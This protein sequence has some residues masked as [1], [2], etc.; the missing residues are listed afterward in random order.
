MT[1][2]GSGSSPSLGVVIPTL[3]E[4][5]YLP[6]LLA[7]LDALA[8]ELDLGAAE[9][10]VVVSDGGSTDAT[11]ELARAAGATVVVTRRGR[12]HQMNAGARVL[13]TPWLLFLYADSRLPSPARACLVERLADDAKKGPAYFRFSLDGDGWFWRA[14]EV[15]QSLRERVTGLAY[16]DQGLLVNRSDLD[17]VGGYSAIPLLEDVAMMRALRAHGNVERLSAAL[18]T[19]PRRFQEEGRWRAWFRN[20]AVMALALI[21]VPPERLASL[22]PARGA[23]DSDGRITLAFAKAPTPGKVKTRLAARIGPTAAADLYAT[24][25]SET[26]QRLRSS[27]YDLYACYDPPSS[28]AEVQA[29]LGEGVTLTPQADGDLGHR[30]WCALR[31]GLEMAS[32]V[33]VV[34]TDVPELDAAIVEEA[35]EGLSRADVVI[36]PADDGGYYLLALKR[37]VRELFED[38][39][40]STSKVLARTLDVAHELDL[41]VRTLKTLRDIDTIDD[42]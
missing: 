38:I 9:L 24:M 27:A 15:G 4:A 1:D 31:D 12:A 22:Y 13:T 5:E 28:A 40:W 2:G 18:P 20:T 3:N 30:M 37:P 11:R 25:A 19:S 39:P 42:L 10:H 16:G 26:M 35:F 33:C 21:G 14:I 36:G 29:W 34:G 6:S 23:T 17:A 8:A 7:D 32:Q 41:T